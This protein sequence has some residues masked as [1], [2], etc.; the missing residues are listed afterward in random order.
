[1]K[2]HKKYRY[3]VMLRGRYTASTKSRE[4]EFFDFA[5]LDSSAL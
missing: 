2:Y 3:V 5:G 4:A 1:M